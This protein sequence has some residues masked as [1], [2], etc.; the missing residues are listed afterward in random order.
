MILLNAVDARALDTEAAASWGLDPFAL[1]EAAGRCCAQ[2]LAAAFPVPP[3]IVIF[4]GSG[5]NAADAMVLLRSLLLSDHVAAERSALVINKVP[6]DG[7]FSEEGAHTPRSGAFLSLQKMGV[8]VL[9]WGNA[10]QANVL[11]DRLNTA[12][13]IIDGIAGTGLEGPLRDQAAEMVNALNKLKEARHNAQ[14]PSPLLIIS[15]DVPSGNSDSWKPGMPIVEADATLA[16]EPLKL[17]LFR[18]AARPYSG[19]I[20][21]VGEVFPPQLIA[22][23]RRGRNLTT[24]DTKGTKEG[25]SLPSV[26]ANRRFDASFVVNPPVAELFGWDHARCLI[27]PVSRTAYK[28]ERGVAEIRAGSP[29]APGA[30]RIAARGAQAAGAGLVR[31]VVDSGLHPILAANAGGVMVAGADAAAGS[32]R[33]NPDAILLGPGWG[34]TPDR[35]DMLA[36]ALEKEAAGIPLILDAD[37]ILLAKDQVFHGN[38]LLTPHPGELAAYAGVSKD[39]IL[40]DPV[41]LL[42]KL[43]EEKN[44]VFLFKSHVMYV[45]APERAAEAM[46]RGSPQ[47]GRIGII[48]G[49]APVLGM[50]GSGDLL[51]GFCAGIAARC[52]ALQGRA[53]QQGGPDLYT[54]AVAAASLLIAS[55]KA[56]P[57]RTPF[58]S[59]RFL[60]PLELA[61]RAA[62]L[63]GE[64]WLT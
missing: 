46:G 16:I 27:P 29:N 61:D 5:S 19:N 53:A 14:N 36:R 10:E 49:M 32:G 43:A 35:E 52:F 55:A 1:V 31:L 20:L 3:R 18:P 9:V 62:D 39:E 24:K 45:V 15:I 13:L 22:Q 2:V 6:A 48:D 33:F 4:A 17:C 38:A 57:A 40:A 51:A 64:A 58:P 41:P 30:A 25:E 44:A 37:A 42:C 60:D 23:F 11:Q 26:F 63:A 7:S 54:C 47:A 12:D 59:R 50:G 21:P 8:P 34:K 56:A 28:Y